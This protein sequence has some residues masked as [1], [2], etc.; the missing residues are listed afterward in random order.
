MNG[1]WLKNQLKKVVESKELQKK[2]SIFSFELL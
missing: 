2:K 1:K